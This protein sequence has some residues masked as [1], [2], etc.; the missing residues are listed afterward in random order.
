MRIPIRQVSESCLDTGKQAI[1]RDPKHLLR[2]RRIVDLHPGLGLAGGAGVVRQQDEQ[3][4][5]ELLGGGSGREAYGDGLGRKL[6]DE[7]TTEEDGAGAYCS[8][9]RKYMQSVMKR[10][11]PK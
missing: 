10:G 4:T 2:T 6:G 3:A 8:H 11:A 9:D 7:E 5:I 1:D